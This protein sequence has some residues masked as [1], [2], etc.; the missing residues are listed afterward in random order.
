MRR[1]KYLSIT[2]TLV[3][4]LTGCGIKSQESDQKTHGKTAASQEYLEN[5]ETKKGVTIGK[6]T[7]SEGI[8]YPV[9]VTDMLGNK[10][11]I[12]RKPERIAAISGTFLALLYA[13]GGES[14]CTSGSSA[15]SP[16]PPAADN[17][18]NI[19]KVF[20]PDVEKII[21]LK[22]DLIIA[23]SG[24]QDNIKPVLTQLGIPV[25][26]FQMKTYDDVIN[27]LG[28]MSR[29]VNQEEAANR[30]IK[31]MESEKKTIVDRLPQASTRAVILYA[32]SQDIGVKLPNSIAGNVAE[33]LKVENI[34]EEAETSVFRTENVPFS[35]ETIIQK[36]PDVILVTSMLGDDTSPQQVI[37][38]KLG[39][40]PLWKNLRA[41]K[42]NRVI[43]LPQKYFLYN[44]GADF[45]K[46]IEYM[47]KAL[48]PD[49]YGD[50]NE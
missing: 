36:D 42:E 15:T 39:N 8:G 28:V 43:Y 14:I 47:A 40:D 9:T 48:Y 11:I 20:N 45:V 3:L 44:A 10:V 24:V 18:P 22:P 2:I 16:V 29:I 37:E 50:L 5:I 38:K 6:V 49:I 33:I 12:E 26:Y 25:L 35:M 27:M 32:T 17:L 19:G 13:V 31:K 34:A 21:S 1:W 23:Q 46:A 4:V 41:V 7:A 30:I